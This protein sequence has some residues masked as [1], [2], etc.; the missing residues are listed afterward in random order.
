M[1]ETL[2]ETVTPFDAIHQDEGRC[3]EMSIRVGPASRWV[4][5]H[6]DELVLHFG[7]TCRNDLIDVSSTQHALQLA[8]MQSVVLHAYRAPADC[9]SRKRND[10]I[11]VAVGKPRW[12]KSSRQNSLEG[13]RFP[14]LEVGCSLNR[15]ILGNTV[16]RSDGSS[17]ENLLPVT[18][19]HL[20][21]APCGDT[22]EQIHS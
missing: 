21:I 16:P 22:T 15:I 13:N 17:A 1:P 19:T 4:K 6:P 18:G 3:A 14:S 8:R 5:D 2:D 9:V 12:R 7:T 11:P 10:S 20:A